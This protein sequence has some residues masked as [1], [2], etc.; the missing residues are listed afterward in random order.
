MLWPTPCTGRAPDGAGGR[1][2]TIGIDAQTLEL[3]VE[4]ESQ[5]VVAGEVG[6][7]PPLG[8]RLLRAGEAGV[9]RIAERPAIAVEVNRGEAVAVMDH[10]AVEP[11]EQVTVGLQA[12][13]DV[14]VFEPLPLIRGQP[15][16]DL[17]WDGQERRLGVLPEPVEDGDAGLGLPLVPLTLGVAMGVVGYLGDAGA[18]A[19]G[20]I[21][22]RE[23]GSWSRPAPG[24]RA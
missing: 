7:D 6:I 19:V 23:L 9:V 5:P 2:G 24:V 12:A 22:G 3:P 14:E 20:R 17:G 13:A 16:A 4:S 1:D 21:L 11:F 18:H 8:D 10:L 15:V